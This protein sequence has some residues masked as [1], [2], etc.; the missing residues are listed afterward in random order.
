MRRQTEWERFFD[1]GL[2]SRMHKN[3]NTKETT[4]NR[5]LSRCR[6]QTVFKTRNAKGQ[7][8]LRKQAIL[9]TLRLHPIPVRKGAIRKNYDK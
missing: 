6:K 1:R 4:P 5:Y 8:M 3:S 7:E 2:T 9:P